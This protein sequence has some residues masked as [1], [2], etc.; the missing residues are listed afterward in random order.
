M[1]R[2]CFVVPPASGG[3]YI[4]VLIIYESAISEIAIIMIAAVDVREQTMILLFH[5]IYVCNI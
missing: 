1:I 2:D 5:Y 4:I 3:G